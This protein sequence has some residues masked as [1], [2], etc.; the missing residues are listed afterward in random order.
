MDIPFID[1]LLKRV[2][3]P[4]FRREFILL[5]QNF[6]WLIVIHNH[7]VEECPEPWTRAYHGKSPF[8]KIEK[9]SLEEDKYERCIERVQRLEPNLPEFCNIDLTS[10]DSDEGKMVIYDP[11]MYVAAHG[12]WINMGSGI[13][14]TTN[15]HKSPLHL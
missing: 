7:S 11:L 4:E 1:D 8:V 2:P 12:H 14:T 3:I 6:E 10:N 15:S 9:K 13:I 5:Q